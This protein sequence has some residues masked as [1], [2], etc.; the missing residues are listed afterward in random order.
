MSVWDAATEL[1]TL[2]GFC[3]VKDGAG[4]ELPDV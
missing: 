4:G 3:M 2:V 1:R